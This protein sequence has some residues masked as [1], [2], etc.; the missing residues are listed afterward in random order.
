MGD[1][2]KL[3]GAIANAQHNIAGQTSILAFKC[4]HHGA[5]LV[6]MEGYGW[7]VLKCLTARCQVKL[8]VEPYALR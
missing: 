5:L 2:E 6:V 7:P 1:T 4:W 8:R 3:T